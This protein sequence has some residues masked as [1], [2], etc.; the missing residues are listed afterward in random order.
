MRPGLSSG[1]GICWR[2]SR[3]AL[4]YHLLSKNSRVSA[5]LNIVLDSGKYLNNI[6]KPLFSFPVYSLLDFPSSLLLPRIIHKPSL[7]T[8]Q[9]TQHTTHYTLHPTHYTLHNAHYTLHTTNYKL[10][11]THYTPHTTHYTIHHTNYFRR[12]ISHERF[13]AAKI[14]PTTHANC[15]ENTK[16]LCASRLKSFS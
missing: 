10:Q 1:L 7:H 11:T 14:R 6:L 12:Q 8:S 13:P 3:V 15:G 4:V 5:G 16:S 9:C 2:K